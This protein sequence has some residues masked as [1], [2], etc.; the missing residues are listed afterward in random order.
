MPIE[1]DLIDNFSEMYKKAWKLKKTKLDKEMLENYV[2]IIMWDTY[3]K[4]VKKPLDA[5]MFAFWFGYAFR[6]I[7]RIVLDDEPPKKGGE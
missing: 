4:Y 1:L 5:Q 7:Y 3:I 6:D 2:M